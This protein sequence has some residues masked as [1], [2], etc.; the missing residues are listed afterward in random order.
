MID[1]IIDRLTNSI[2]NTISGDQFNTEIIQAF[3]D[4]KGITKKDWAFDWK[5]EIHD[6]DKEVYKLVIV[7]NKMKATKE[8]NSIDIEVVN[9]PMTIEEKQSFSEFLKTRK[10]KKV[11]KFT[12]KH[13]HTKAN[14]GPQPVSVH[15]EK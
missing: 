5:K 2:R 13:D 12:R 15:L 1:I 6:V 11:R 4:E 3:I 14:H 8:N 7:N 9:R 10:K